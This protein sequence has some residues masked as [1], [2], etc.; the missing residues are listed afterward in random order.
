MDTSE[1]NF[2]SS[3]EDALVRGPQSV[4]GFDGVREEEEPYG[5]KG[6]RKRR[7]EDYDKTLCL[8]AD[9]VLDFIR[10][11]Q[12]ATWE[13]LKAQRGQPVREQFLKRL[14]KEIESRGTL[15]V[16]RKGVTDLGCTFSLAF[17]Q[18]ESRLNPEHLRLYKANIFSII[19]QLHYSEKTDGS[20]DLV[21]FLNG[22]PIFTAELKN[23]L[24]S[25]TVENAI[26][27]Y[28]TDRDPREPLLKFRR[29]LAH[30]AADTDL[31]FM[32]TRLDGQRTRFLPFNKGHNNGSGNPPDPA[33]FRTAYLWEQVWQPDSLLEIVDHFVQLVDVFDEDDRPTSEKE[34]VFPRYH[35]LDTVRRLVAHAR[36][37]GPGHS[38]L[39]EHSAGSGKS[40]TIAWLAHQLAGLHGAA[41]KRVFDSVI[42]I[43]DRRVLD[44]QL[45]QTVKSFEQT[46]GL[47]FAV[48]QDKSSKLAEGLASGKDIIVT[49][50]QT[51]PFLADKLTQIKGRT[52]AVLIDEAHSSQTGEASRSLKQTLAGPS[53]RDDDD[54]DGDQPDDEDEINRRVEEL[55]KKTG[56][57][58]NVSFFAFTATPKS[59]TME[60]FG[61]PQPDG[62]FK[63]FSLYSM[64]QAIEEKFILD[65]L[66]NYTT[67]KVYFGLNKRVE[68]D[69]DYP[70]K[71]AVSLLKSYVDVHE[72]AI[73]QK[74]EIIIEH[75]VT[76]VKDRIKGK[77]KA[78]VVSKSRRQAV[79]Y[80]LMFDR[81]L[82]ERR[83]PY[84]ALVAFSGTVKDN[85]QDYTEPGMNHLQSEAQTAPTFKQPECR[86]LIVAEKFQTGFDQPLLHTMYVDKKLSGVNA[87]QTLSRL[88][89]MY[90]PDKGETMVLDFVNP[91]AE[92][93]KAF[94]PYYETTLLTEP[95]DPNKL[96]DLKR[97][98][99]EHGVY[100]KQDV[101]DFAKA[102]FAKKPSQQKVRAALDP[103]VERYLAKGRDERE[104]FKGQATDYVRMYAFLS[105]ILQFRDA[106]LEKTYQFLRLLRPLLPTERERL[107]V[108]VIEKIN[109]DSYRV[110]QTSTG[111]IALL[112]EEGKLKPASEVGTRA[113]G[114][115]DHI[116]LSE[117][118]HY[119][120][121]NY[122]TDFTDEDKVRFF[123]QDMERRLVEQDGL[124]QALDPAIN[125]PEDVRRLAFKTFF[126]DVL[127]D[128]FAANA[129]LYKKIVDDERFGEIFRGVMFRKVAED[130]A[131]GQG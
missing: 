70:K 35:Q 51:F 123:A 58:P 6:Y 64:R 17:F 55:M 44:R 47:V 61:E 84:R 94:Q 28:K 115:D 10:A 98:A 102:Y 116:P 105:H 22:L 87:V 16:L 25:Q 43:T 18:P 36:A 31:V 122:G 113:A 120:N 82:A 90:P 93:Q 69:P 12:P 109:M 103:I 66:R 63:P 38:Y 48:D 8:D 14:A 88:N 30:F 42:V 85:G 114:H 108:E 39:V 7:S 68:D 97:M 41:D 111:A 77:A 20:I 124:R 119:I 50:V 75:F 129:A 19:R 49:T 80:K 4:A 15:D 76:Q 53:Q 112:D 92:I 100:T 79:H 29:C 26:A 62:T 106:E 81:V 59:K 46:R 121:E 128:M 23:P 73:R 32:T 33:G 13:K 54:G 78:M 5:V 126:D 2:E 127:E 117:I 130:F 99:D 57:L 107:P 83:L 96:Y 27:Q 101:A 74:T 71:K 104:E 11:T 1:R 131:Q 52:F 67:F 110:Q 24:K 60:L 3:I 45:R 72:H 37:S 65:V 21:I 40:K 118:V 91:A 86:F 34:Q 9:V 89:R 95:T 56:R 125:P